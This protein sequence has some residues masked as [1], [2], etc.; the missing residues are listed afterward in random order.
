MFIIST[1][2][3]FL[4]TLTLKVSAEWME[5]NQ[6]LKKLIYQHSGSNQ[7]KNIIRQSLEICSTQLCCTTVSLTNAPSPRPS[8]LPKIVPSF[9]IKRNYSIEMNSLDSGI[10][11]I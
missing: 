3:F 8:P 4:I 10:Q 7:D 2:F 9:H 1:F 6:L 5:T 11:K